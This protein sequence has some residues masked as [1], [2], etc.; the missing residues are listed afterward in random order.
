MLFANK[1]GA[2]AVLLADTLESAYGALSP[3]AASLLLT[4][5]YTPNATATALAKVAGISQPTAV[6][7]LDGLVR[8]GL[9]ERKSHTGRTTLLRVT[10]AGRARAVSLQVG[11]LGA[12]E[13]ILS[14]LNT[15]DRAT[16][17]RILDTI[18]PSCVRRTTLSH[19]RPRERDRTDCRH[20]NPWGPTC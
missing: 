10:R 2:F 5:Y 8:Q 16:F 14:G 4:L 11:R 7:V 15:Q 9:I 1:L 3:S 18:R 19:R 20:S 13:K 17:E 12:M 6:R